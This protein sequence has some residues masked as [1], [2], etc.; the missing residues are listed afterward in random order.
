VLLNPEPFY[1]SVRE[2]MPVFETR[3]P[4][5]DRSVFVVTSYD[6]VNQAQ[7]GNDG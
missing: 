7:A 5:R 4:G 3:L 6:L 1:A 2:H